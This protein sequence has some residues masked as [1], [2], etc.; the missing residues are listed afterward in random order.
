MALIS[1]I[2][3]LLSRK[4]GDLLQA[5]F[6]WSIR[7]LFGKLPSRKETALSVALI[8][9]VL[10][11]LLV[12]G[13]FL[14]KAAAWMVAFIPLHEWLGKEVLRVMWI[15]LAVIAPICSCPMALNS[16]YSVGESLPMKKSLLGTTIDAKVK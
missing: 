10:W 14:P 16:L 6:G 3:S 5:L 1:A 15:A 7:G 9:S 12:I 8:L 2:L 11:P 13:S 4:L